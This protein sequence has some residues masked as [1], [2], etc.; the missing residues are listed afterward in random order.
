MINPLATQIL[1]PV[2]KTI[3]SKGSNEESRLP[4]R[5]SRQGG[6]G[7][8]SSIMQDGGLGFLRSRLEESM[9]ALFEKAAEENPDL[10]A[11]GPA[12]F[13]GTGADVSPEATADRIVGFALGLKGIYSRQN[14]EMSHEE[15]M[16]G[17]EAEIRRGI[18]DGFGNARGILGG[19]DLLNEQV[20]NNVDETW[21]LVQQKLENF[22]HPPEEE[23]SD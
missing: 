5:T 4:A 13:F 2:P 11:A 17:F 15:M 6:E 23:V 1:P 8:A 7:L 16:A 14:S 19:L 10:E 12:A 3:G 18:S 22:F 20:E 9:G 21:D